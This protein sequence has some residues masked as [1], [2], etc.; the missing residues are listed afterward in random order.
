MLKTLFKKSY[1]SISPNE[2]RERLKSNKSVI[3]LDVRSPAEYAEL[4]I[5]KDYMT[6]EEMQLEIIRLENEIAEYEDVKLEFE[7]Q[8]YTVETIQSNGAK[9]DR[10]STELIGD[11]LSSFQCEGVE[12]QISPAL[13]EL[14]SEYNRT[15]D[16]LYT[17]LENQKND[18]QLKIDKKQDEII[19][20]QRLISIHQPL[21]NYRLGVYTYES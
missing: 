7:K 21:Q 20:L 2:A 8:Y 11:I 16:K 10:E 1:K 3:L 18:I 6:T 5:P 9:V 12:S 14:G 15:S 19:E 13:T 17:A 4:H